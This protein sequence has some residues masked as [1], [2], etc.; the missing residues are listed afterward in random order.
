[1]KNGKQ[2][3]ALVLISCLFAAA[4]FAATQILLKPSMIL[5]GS[6]GSPVAENSAN[7]GKILRLTDGTLIVVYGDA[8]DSSFKAWDYNG[9]IYSAR[10]TFVSWSKDDGV[11][12]TEP[13]NISN[14]ASQTDVGKFYDRDGNGE[15]GFGRWGAMNFYGG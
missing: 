1:M 15:D 6:T 4:V 5:S 12:W 11:T 7:K 10:D 9:D 14:T 13:L 2:K 8:I 3:F